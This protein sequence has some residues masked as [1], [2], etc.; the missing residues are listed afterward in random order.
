MPAGDA[1]MNM[2]FH[3]IRHFNL[4]AILVSALFFWV[5]GAAWY[6]PALFAKPWMA[7]L[8]IIPCDTK[9]GFVA[10]MISSLVGDLLS[11]FVMLHFILWSGADN[12][13]TGAFIGFLYWLGFFAAIQFPQGLYQ[14][15]PLVLFAIDGGYFLIGMLGMGAILA[16]WR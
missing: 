13:W 12:I 5:L 10:A 3:N 14:R 1:M 15:R 4:W 8:H 9:P 11:A 6:S 7:A 16:V 2:S